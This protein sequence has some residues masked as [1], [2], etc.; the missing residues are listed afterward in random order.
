M[1]SFIKLNVSV[2]KTVIVVTKTRFHESYI[3]L[4]LENMYSSILNIR[5]SGTAVGFWQYI[6]SCKIL[7]CYENCPI[8]VKITCLDYF[9]LEISFYSEK[10]LCNHFDYVTKIV[11]NKKC[12]HGL[13]DH[14]FFYSIRKH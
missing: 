4:C 8:E 13:P 10:C 3:S 5:E 11:I 1:S 6:S 7:K 9:Q 14:L 2:A 12:K